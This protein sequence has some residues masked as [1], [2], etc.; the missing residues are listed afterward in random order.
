MNPN[1]GGQ[2]PAERQRQTAA[3]IARKKVLAAYSHSANNSVTHPQDHQQHPQ[4]HQPPNNLKS[5]PQNQQVTNAEWHR[6]HSAWQNYYQ[7]YYS[8][9]YATAARNYVAKEKLKAHRAAEDERKRLEEAGIISPKNSVENPVE[10]SNNLTTQSS[11]AT[12]VI[13]STPDPTEVKHDFRERIRHR[14]AQQAKNSSRKHKRLIPILAGIAVVLVFLFLQDNRLIFAPIVAYVSPGNDADSSSITPV[15]PTITETVGAENKLII[16][17]LNIDVPVHF[18]ISNDESTVMSAMNNGVAQF[19]IPGA[20]AN[21][22]ENGNVVI[23][24]HS[25]GDIYSSNPY[26]FIFSGLERLTEGDLIY[27]NYQS[28]RYTYKVTGH[29]T[30]EPTDVAALLTGTNKP[31]LT[32]VTCTPLGTSR[33]R[34]LVFA[35]QVNPAPSTNTETTDT[36]TGTDVPQTQMPANEDT[37]FEGIWKFLTGQS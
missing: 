16:P 23:T 13:T 14:A 12:G 21:P 9:Y 34:L 17:K 11:P 6:Y 20:S 19:A 4:G 37:F 31:M 15:D 5:T 24:G 27:I 2:T 33:Y 18:G 1:P 3:E 7:K 36:S 30:V 28:K 25:A 8:E 10:N 26:K 32:L 22:G 29:D 35:D